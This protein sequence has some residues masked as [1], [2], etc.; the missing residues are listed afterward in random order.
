MRNLKTQWDRRASLVWGAATAALLVAGQAAALPV[1]VAGP[2]AVSP[3][4]AQP[5][6]TSGSTAV[7][8]DLNAAR[9]IIDWSNFNLNSGEQ[10]NFSF[11]QRNHFVLNR[12]TSSAININGQVTGTGP[13]GVGG[14]I[15]FYSPQGVIFGPNTRVNAGGMLATSAA[16]DTTAFLT[17]G[18]INIPFTGSGS[19]GPVTVAGGAQFN[20]T[21][22]I[23]FVAPRV[24]TAAGSTVTV[25]DNGTALYGAADSYEI[26]FFPTGDNDLTLFTFIVPSAAAGTP[27]ST[28]LNVAGTTTS[29]TIYLAAISRAAVAGQIINAPGLLTARS[30]FVEY[31]QVTITTGRTI[32]LG[33]VGINSEAQQI[34]GV[35][36]GS[37]NI[38]T[39]NADGNVNVWLTGAGSLGS[40][41]ATGIRSGQALNIAA[42]NVTIGSGGLI[43]GDS[44]DPRVGTRRN[45]FID[46]AGTLTSPLLRSG[47]E[48]NVVR[49]AA[50]VGRTTSQITFRVGTVTSAAKLLFNGGGAIDAGVI[51]SG[52]EAQIFG[53]QPVNI[54]SLTT[55]GYTRISS[56]QSI[57]VGAVR[58]VDLDLRSTS[59]IT[60]SSLTGS[61]S[62]MVGTGGPAIIGSITGPSL[63]LD[64]SLARLGV[65]N[66]GGDIR[67]RI[68][69]LD[70]LTSLSAANLTIESQTGGVTLGGNLDPGLTDAEFQRIRVTG[71]VNI[72]A[73]VQA[74]TVNVPVPVYGDITVRDLELNPT[75]VPRLNLYAHNTRDVLF[76]G[77]IDVTA[78]GGFM[79]IG[80]P[81]ADSVWKPR[82][83][84]LMDPS[85]PVTLA[86]LENFPDSVFLLR[87]LELYASND[88]LIGSQRFVDLVAGTPS[89]QIDI[90]RGLPLGVEANAEELGRIYLAAD[91]LVLSAGDRIL[92]Q[93]TGGPGGALGTYISGRGIAEGEPLLSIGGG[94]KVDIVVSLPSATGLV[95]GQAAALSQRIVRLA[96]DTSQN[97]VLVNG[98]ALGV[99]CRFSTPATQFRVESFR[100]AA[101]RAAIDPPVLAPPPPVDEDEREAEAVITGTGNEE[102]WRDHK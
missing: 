20:A 41:T 33:Q 10:A 56:S 7:S 39:V 78:N 2:Y 71:A 8:V 84:K 88:I 5:V 18:N 59:G 23:A 48:I 52:G 81:A 92:Q 102:I 69:T 25:N 91:S 29:G 13:G 58:G 40:L 99:G 1:P 55:N 19:G 36:T 44:P 28:P 64:A 94:A 75:R 37:V 17:P 51:T 63:L 30:S 73:G 86:D 50:Q 15:F 22:F 89:D 47:G 45:L 9:T 70:L 43:S 66:V 34:A 93:N 77:P 80:D 21:A 79:R 98:C 3:G 54:T 35:T 11:D 65:V 16:P 96:G 85:E 95:S 82:A 27:L 4:G 74:P 76:F 68:S 12:V 32:L 14:N 57:T 31:G 60:A 61:T 100:P 90:G 62:V 6:I 42:Q 24:D 67:L 97:T 53:S 101:T 49:G 87:K 83:I 46:M 38:G 26:Q 72:Y